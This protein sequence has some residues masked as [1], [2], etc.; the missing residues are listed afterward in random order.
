VTSASCPPA[1]RAD[2]VDQDR[3]PLWRFGDKTGRAAAVGAIFTRAGKRYRNPA[4]PVAESAT[5]PRNM[6]QTLWVP[7][8]PHPEG[9]AGPDNYA[10]AAV[11]FPENSEQA[12]FLCPAL[13]QCRGPPSVNDTVTAHLWGEQECNMQS[14]TAGRVVS[15]VQHAHGR[16]ATI[17]P[18]LIMRRNNV[19]CA[20]SFA[21]TSR[22]SDAAPRA[23]TARNS[24]QHGARDPAP[25]RRPK[26]T[27]NC[28]YPC[29][30]VRNDYS[31][32]TPRAGRWRLIRLRAR[33]AR[34]KAH[35]RADFCRHQAGLAPVWRQGLR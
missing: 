19:A 25:S 18:S 2:V 4:I 33:D 28:L 7:R 10:L 15:G 34:Q 30:L 22:K 16:S 32:T 3:Q 29:R 23:A 1:C 6:G 11:T 27:S 26:T 20:P 21:V 35:P 24:P 14:R 17:E 8:P 12:V 9:L 5:M 31:M 13:S